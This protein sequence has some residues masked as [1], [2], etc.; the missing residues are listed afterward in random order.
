MNLLHAAR[1]DLCYMFVNVQGAPWI[2]LYMLLRGRGFEAAGAKWAELWDARAPTDGLISTV[3]THTV[4]AI[5]FAYATVLT[6]ARQPH[7]P[8]ITT[9]VLMVCMVGLIGSADLFWVNISH[10]FSLRT[11]DSLIHHSVGVV[12]GL[13][14]F[15]ISFASMM[16]VVID[17]STT[18]DLREHILKE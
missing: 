16:I 14:F 10:M 1:K 4:L 6:L 2:A 3:T 13:M 18:V 11:M 8:L 9:V 12:F 5:L 17:R 7:R 15:I